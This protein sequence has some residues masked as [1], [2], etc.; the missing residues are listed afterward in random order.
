M[1]KRQTKTETSREQ[2][3]VGF[4]VTD[5]NLEAG[6]FRGLASVFGSPVDAWVPTIVDK[7]AFTKTLAADGKNVK[8][9]WQHSPDCPIGIPLS[10]QETDLGLEVTGKISMTE[11]GKDALTLLRDGV[12]DG[13][14]IGFDPIVYE[15]VKQPDGSEM[16]HLKEVKLWEFSVVT[17][18][19]DSNARISAVHERAALE[20]DEARD[21]AFAAVLV[22]LSPAIETH[23]GKVLSTKNA[24]LV[25]DA[26]AALQKLLEAATPADDEKAHRAAVATTL[27]LCDAD[28]A[29][30]S[31]IH[32]H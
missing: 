15:S 2:F 13:L 29:L 9:L 30:G 5:T 24:A 19:A 31:A 28:L 10:M 22:S 17:F 25:T 8:I 26:I 4:Q 32:S 18:P 1:G 14:S 20:T 3:R 16:R 6:T 7:G 23:Q 27:A 21:E 12:I 11:Q